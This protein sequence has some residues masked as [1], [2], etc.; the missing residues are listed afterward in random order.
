MECKGCSSS[1]QKPL[2]TLYVGLTTC[3]GRTYLMDLVR[4]TPRDTNFPND[5]SAVLRFELVNR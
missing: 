3:D 2:L 4:V 5:V 1:Y